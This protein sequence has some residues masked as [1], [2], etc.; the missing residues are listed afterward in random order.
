[1]LV[2]VVLPCGDFAGEVLFVGNAAIQTLRRQNPQLGFG[3]VDPAKRIAICCSPNLRTA[4]PRR[5]R[6]LRRLP[7]VQD[8][9]D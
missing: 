5:Q 8:L 6:R 3:H 4:H 1:M 2:A 7:A 9:L